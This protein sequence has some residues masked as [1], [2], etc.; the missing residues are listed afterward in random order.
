MASVVVPD[1]RVETLRLATDTQRILKDNVPGVAF[2]TTIN[3]HGV[4][5]AVDDA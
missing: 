4:L 2:T 3:I 5:R 1:I